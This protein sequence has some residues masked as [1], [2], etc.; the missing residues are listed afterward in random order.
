MSRYVNRFFD[1]GADTTR[2]VT[3]DYF[4]GILNDIRGLFHS[5][6][7]DIFRRVDCILG[8]EAHRVLLGICR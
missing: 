2:D 5:V 8:I 6:S 3:F 1:D 7:R 4:A